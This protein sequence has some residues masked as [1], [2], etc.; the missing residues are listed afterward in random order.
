MTDWRAIA[1]ARGISGS[2]EELERM[3]ATLESLER[4]FAP[5]ARELPV[6]LEPATVFRAAT[7][8]DM[9]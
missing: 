1:K 4:V 8:S 9:H 7:A 6:D 2:R 5:L 3:A